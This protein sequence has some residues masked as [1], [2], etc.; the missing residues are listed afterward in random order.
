MNHST[1]YRGPEDMPTEPTTNGPSIRSVTPLQLLGPLANQEL[2]FAPTQ[3]CVRGRL[4]LPLLHPRV[5][6]VGTR[7]PSVG[8]L[9]LASRV[10]TTLAENGVIVVSGLARGIDTAA[11]V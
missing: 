3:L 9:R 6:I 11:H 8:G 7:R 10:A 4:Q 2:K 1:S 5:A